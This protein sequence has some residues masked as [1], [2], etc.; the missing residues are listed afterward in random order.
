[1]VTPTLFPF[2]LP[3][4]QET[5]QFWEQDVCHMLEMFESAENIHSAS[6]KSMRKPHGHNLM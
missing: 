1:M 4:T 2:F 5:L 6:A 3:I